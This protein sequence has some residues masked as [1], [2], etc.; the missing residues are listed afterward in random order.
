MKTDLTTGDLRYGVA[1]HRIKGDEYIVRDQP[2][3]TTEMYRIESS[4]TNVRA[5]WTA[6]AVLYDGEVLDPVMDDIGLISL[7]H[8][9]AGTRESFLPQEWLDEPAWKLS[10]VPRKSNANVDANT[11]GR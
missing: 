9:W 10:R 8:D 1:L 6:D 5:L 11:E 7:V 3:E 2:E 4:T